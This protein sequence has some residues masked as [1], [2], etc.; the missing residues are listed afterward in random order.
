MDEAARIAQQAK[1]NA[2]DKA[3]ASLSK[4]NKGYESTSISGASDI[5]V[6]KIESLQ[7][8]S[9]KVVGQDAN[10]NIKEA[11]Y[12]DELVVRLKQKLRLP[13]YGVVELKLTLDRSGKVTKLEVT[14]F[15][16]D[17]NKK[18]V[19][20]EMPSLSFPPFGNNFASAENY[21]FTITLDNEL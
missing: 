16:S 10:L 13:K 17:L 14:K 6:K 5:T 20:K 18:H 3:R 7:I 1:Q 8:E 19:E 21:T 15:A 2:L 9:I 11:G 12:I 4:V